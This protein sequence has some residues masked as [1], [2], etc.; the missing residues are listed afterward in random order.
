MVTP[1]LPNLKKIAGSATASSVAAGGSAKVTITLDSIYVIVGVPEVS[2]ST[3]NAEVE[4]VNG[5]KNEFTVKAINNGAA[6]QDIAIDYEVYVIP[7]V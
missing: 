5:G 3:T 7:D 2:T 1:D 4:L 6:A